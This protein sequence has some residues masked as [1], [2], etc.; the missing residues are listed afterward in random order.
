MFS[1]I[2]LNLDFHKLRRTFGQ[3]DD[4]QKINNERVLSFFYSSSLTRKFKIVSVEKD[5]DIRG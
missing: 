4:N 2:D 5:E 3:N 1:Q